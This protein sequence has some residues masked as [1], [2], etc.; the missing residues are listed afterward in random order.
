MFDTPLYFYRFIFMAEL[1]LAEGL[2][3]HKLKKRSRFPLRVALS[4]L[5]C[6]GVT[7][8]FPIITFDA[9]YVS[10]M[11]IILFAMTIGAL[12]FCYA[13]RLLDIVFCAVAA[14]AVQHIAYE[15]YTFM[16]VAFGLDTGTLAYGETISGD[17]SFWMFA[18]YVESY[19][20][21]YALMYVFFGRRIGEKDDLNIGNVSLLVIS[22][23]IVLVA[24]LFNAILT[25]RVTED[26]DVVIMSMTH[27]YNMICCVLAVAIQFS[28]LG[29]KKM[30]TELDTLQRLHKQEQQHYMIFKEN[31]DY[32]NVKC[33][34]LK[35][36]IRR[37]ASKGAVGD[38]V[39]DE[40][41]NAV[42]IYD[43]D[44]KSGNEILDIVLTE[45]RLTCVNNNIAFSC[46]TDGKQI[47]FM[48][49]A[50]ICAL[51]GNALDNAIEAVCRIPE[52]EKRSIGLIIKNV[53]GFVSVNVRNN[54][55][56]VPQFDGDLP[57]STKGDEVYH[58]YGMKSIKAVTERY[59]GEMSVVVKDGVFS[60][61]LLFSENCT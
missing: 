21:A 39:I 45:K 40:I 52:P 37:I 48:S 23:V 58:G 36:Q 49:D 22:G 25:Y 13:M 8:V 11:F 29:K 5:V 41:E 33:H 32:I 26:T 27:I 14:Y 34:D 10:A 3:T 2:F 60:L 7:A 24:V 51:F 30:Q 17:Y 18:T 46:I 16:N 43:S 1:F 50:D 38:S 47:N 54:C 42:S 53:K 59:G 55:L 19:A 56:G 31:I 9:L 28:I 12:Y 4:L 20:A 44:V 61:N 35:H 15:L 6:Y 57:R